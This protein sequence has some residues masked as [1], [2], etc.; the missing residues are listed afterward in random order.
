MWVV[1]FGIIFCKYL[2]MNI[3]KIYHTDRVL[4][5]FC[6]WSLPFLYFLPD[7]AS[8]LKSPRQIRKSPSGTPKVYEVERQHYLVT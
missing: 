4:S 6:W 8:E 2:S 5:Y 7:F 1:I 3:I